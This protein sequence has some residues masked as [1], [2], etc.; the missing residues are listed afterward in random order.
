MITGNEF[1]GEYSIYERRTIT[2][3]RLRDEV[4]NRDLFKA[5]VHVMRSGDCQLV[6]YH[7]A[8]T[9]CGN[10]FSTTGHYH[11]WFRWSWSDGEGYYR[12]DAWRNFA[13]KIVESDGEDAVYIVDGSPQHCKFPHD[14]RYHA[15]SMD[16]WNFER[17]L[18]EFVTRDEE[19][20]RYIFTNNESI[21]QLLIDRGHVVEPR[22]TEVPIV[23]GQFGPDGEPVRVTAA[24]PPPNSLDNVD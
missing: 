12:T 17:Y 6:T 19:Q 24:N 22:P 21:R 5:F 1:G 23:I 15:R 18:T 8:N 13:A 7:D 4:G 11:L 10:S 20:H 2:K 3:H 16:M 14:C 9:E